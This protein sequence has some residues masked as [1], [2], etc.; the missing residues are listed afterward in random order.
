MSSGRRGARRVDGY[1]PRWGSGGKGGWVGWEAKARRWG[2]SGWGGGGGRRWRRGGGGGGRCGRWAATIWSRT[3][4]RWGKRQTVVW[5]IET[6]RP[7]VQ[8]GLKRPRRN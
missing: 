7:L 4:L 2:G 1:M 5:P 8:M 6:M 3:S